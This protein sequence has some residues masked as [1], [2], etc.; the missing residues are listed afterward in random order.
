MAY[1]KQKPSKVSTSAGISL[2]ADIK[3]AAADMAAKKHVSLSAYVR[4]M[5]RADLQSAGYRIEEAG[6]RNLQK[7]QGKVERSRKK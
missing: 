1:P 3:A 2:P 6:Q 5:L 4:E 7:A